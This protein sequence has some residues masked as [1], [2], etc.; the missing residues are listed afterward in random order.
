MSVPS[1]F[2]IVTPM[3]HVQTQMAHFRVLATAAT[4]AMELLALMKTNVR[5]EQTTVTRTPHVPTRT[6][7]LHAQVKIWCHSFLHFVIKGIFASKGPFVKRLVLHLITNYHTPYELS[8]PKYSIYTF[9][10][11]RHLKIFEQNLTKHN[12]NF[13]YHCIFRVEDMEW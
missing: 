9:L 13:S 1:I 2:T 12:V 3:L 11:L 7:D 4:L 8:H 5:W 10:E 6:V